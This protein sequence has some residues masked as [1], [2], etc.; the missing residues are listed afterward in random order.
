MV[1][2]GEVRCRV[3]GVPLSGRQVYE[4]KCMKCLEDE[5]LSE[6]D[7]EPVTTDED[8]KLMIVPLE[9]EKKETT[10]KSVKDKEGARNSGIG[11]EQSAE[12]VISVQKADEILK[13][14]RS[15]RKYVKRLSKSTRRLG[16]LSFPQQILFG[17][18]VGLGLLLAPI[19]FCILLLVPI[20]ILSWLAANGIVDMPRLA[21]LREQLREAIFRFFSSLTGKG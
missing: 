6:T 14:L 18:R 8:T 7:E 2:M 9:G 4:G 11:K 17:V 5:V 16:D 1:L 15:I 10:E 19:V 13:E 12:Q 3:C 20:A 21:E